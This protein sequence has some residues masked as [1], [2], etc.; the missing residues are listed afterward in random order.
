MH[1]TQLLL[2]RL[3]SH[4]R[5]QFIFGVFTEVANEATRLCLNP[6]ETSHIPACLLRASRWLRCVL[7]GHCTETANQTL[8]AHF[9]TAR[10]V[11]A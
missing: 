7:V 6:F 9:I 4:V 5:E 8:Q 1:F 10:C 3:N 11:C 2:I